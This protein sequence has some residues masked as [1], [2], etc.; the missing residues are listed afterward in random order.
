MTAQV[1]TN[2]LATIVVPTLRAANETTVL[3]GAVAVWTEG[4][5]HADVAGISSAV[6]GSDGR[7]VAFEA[8]SGT[9]RFVVGS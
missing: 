8:G 2:S 7:S 5:F 3:E 9:Y 6:A 4:R 1:P